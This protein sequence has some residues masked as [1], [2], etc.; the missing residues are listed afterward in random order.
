M[1]VRE[2]T[3]LRSGLLTT[4]QDLGRWGHQAAGVPVAGA[5][6]TYSLRLANALV[7][8]ASTAAV[9]EV[10]LAGPTLRAEGSVVVATAGAVFELWLDDRLVPH[11]AAIEVPAGAVVRFGE[12]RQATRAYLAVAGGFDTPPVLGSRS[13]HLISGMGGVSGRALA[14]GDVL[15]V[16][17][18]S[19]AP[20]GR[21]THARPASS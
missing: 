21:A 3:V 19:P 1:T 8:N 12:R 14:A 4:V 16:G 11:G 9:L 13:T 2:L 6:D 10:T 15:P 7:G 5:M 20:S 18:S 17:M